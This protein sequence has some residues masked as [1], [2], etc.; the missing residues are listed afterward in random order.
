M[1]G[2]FTSFLLPLQWGGNLKSW[3][4]P[5]VIALFAVSAALLFVFLIWERFLGLKSMVPLQLLVR[6]TQLG[7]AIAGV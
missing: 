2:S 1:L 3:S 5:T 4:D 6:R 7:G